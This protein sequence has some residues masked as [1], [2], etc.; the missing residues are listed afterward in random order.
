MN[1]YEILEFVCE[2]LIDCVTVLLPS[3]SASLNNDNYAL[4]TSD[5]QCQSTTQ[6]ILI[7]N[8][9]NDAKVWRFIPNVPITY[10]N[11]LKFQS[12]NFHN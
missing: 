6:N 1:V 12:K 7:E 8:S 3:L 11:T 10:I 2:L 5:I 9:I 4:Q